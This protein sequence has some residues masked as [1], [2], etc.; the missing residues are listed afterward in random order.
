MMQPLALAV[1]VSHCRERP[2]WR[3][4][5]FRWMVHSD[6]RNATEGVP[7]SPRS[8][9]SSRPRRSSGDLRS[10]ERRGQRPAP[11][12]SAA[13][14]LRAGGVFH[15]VDVPAE[16]FDFVGHVSQLEHVFDTLEQL[17]LVNR[18]A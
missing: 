7:Y 4:E 15:A 8:A 14:S 5:N 10:V 1:W 6:S 13:L 16:A 2:P 18:L 17:D 11:S 12:E 9:R 3:S